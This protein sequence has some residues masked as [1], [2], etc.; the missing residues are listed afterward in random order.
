MKRFVM[1]VAATLVS[2]AFSSTVLAQDKPAAPADSTTKRIQSPDKSN[3]ERQR[4]TPAAAGNTA[5]SGQAQV[6]EVR[7]WGAIDKNKDH[8][9]SADEM[10]AYL[11]QSRKK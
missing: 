5:R 11:Q 8:L 2:A 1:T 7:D 3:V 10:E 9:V 4:N 6:G